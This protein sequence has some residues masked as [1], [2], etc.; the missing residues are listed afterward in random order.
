MPERTVTSM[1][2]I[3]I[4][5][6]LILALVGWKLFPSTMSWWGKRNTS[7]VDYFFSRIGFA[8]GFPFLIWVLFWI[9]APAFLG[10]SQ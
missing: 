3:L 10:A 2:N 7:A 6:Y 5:L 8:A 4:I 9:F 1:D